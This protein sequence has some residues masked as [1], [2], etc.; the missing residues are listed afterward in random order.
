V[1]HLVA[2]EVD[3]EAMV[4]DRAHGLLINLDQKYPNF[5]HSRLA[6]GVK[7]SSEF[8]EKVF[9]ECLGTLLSQSWRSLPLLWKLISRLSNYLCSL[10]PRRGDSGVRIIQ[11]VHIVQ[12]K[13]NE[14]QPVL[15]V[16]G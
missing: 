5:L 10:Y 15:D 1:P 16:D 2:L 4:A 14:P 9:T 6:E 11:A 12:P 8:Q 7:L 13:T 3:R